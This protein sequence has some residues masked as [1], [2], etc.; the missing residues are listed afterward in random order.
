MSHNCTHSSNLK[1]S[2]RSRSLWLTPPSLNLRQK[3]CFNKIVAAAAAALDLR[4]FRPN[5]PMTNLG[6]RAGPV[7]CAQFFA[8]AGWS[9]TKLLTS[10]RRKETESR[11][12][13]AILNQYAT[14][15][16]WNRFVRIH[17]EESTDTQERSRLVS[18]HLGH[19]FVRVSFLL[20]ASFFSKICC[21]ASVNQDLNS[22]ASSRRRGPPGRGVASQCL[23]WA[24]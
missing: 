16:H 2:F 4:T 12:F 14:R 5:F 11:L 6:P 24:R 3:D 20:S 15:A 7:N 18:Q 13:K 22:L 23:I 8:R 21:A 9:N 17:A 19:H 10:L 1:T